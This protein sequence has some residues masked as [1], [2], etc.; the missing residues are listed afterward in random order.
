MYKLT[1]KK[2]CNDIYC[3]TYSEAVMRAQLNGLRIGQYKIVSVH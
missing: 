3:F 2:L 1:S